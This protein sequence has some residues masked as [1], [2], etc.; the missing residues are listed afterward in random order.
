MNDN[1]KI[2]V[3]G[4]SW[5][6]DDT[7]LKNAFTAYG[8]VEEAKVITDRMT[9]RSRGFGFVTFDNA[10][11]VVEALTF[12]GQMLDGRAIRVDRATRRDR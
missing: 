8:T 10:D 5:D 3:G 6:T 1:K 11:A 2:F 7:G 12:D 9:G 4:L